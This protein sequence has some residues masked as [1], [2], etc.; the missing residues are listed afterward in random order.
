MLRET[1]KNRT[2]L[3]ANITFH[4]MTLRGLNLI[5]K[6]KCHKRDLSLNAFAFISSSDSLLL[7]HF[8]AILAVNH[9]YN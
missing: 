3:F 9:E 7:W 2:F 5:F 4:S 6:Y 8:A 1:N